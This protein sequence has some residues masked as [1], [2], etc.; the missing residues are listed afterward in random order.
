VVRALA[1]W[2]FSPLKERGKD[3]GYLIHLKVPVRRKLDADLELSQRPIWQPPAEISAAM[4]VSDNLDAP[5]AA[6]MLANLPTG[7]AFG[8]FRTSLLVYYAKNGYKDAENARKVRRELI[9]WLIRTFPQDSILASP[10]AII[11]ASGEPLADREGAALVKNEWLNALKDYPNDEAVLEG[12]VNFLRLTDPS[13]ALRLPAARTDYRFRS[14]WLGS[15]YAFAGL[16][17]NAVAPASGEPLTTESPEF[18][19]KV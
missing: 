1:H 12:A 3:S 18:P 5:K 2:R 17:V 10:Y 9:L 14:N 6:E 4:K 7:E 8:H 11:N 16:G 13:A 19:P 15:L